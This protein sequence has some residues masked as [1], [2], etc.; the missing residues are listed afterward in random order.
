MGLLSHILPQCYIVKTAEAC[1]CRSRYYLIMMMDHDGHI[2][3]F[4][5]T[6][7]FSKGQKIS[8]TIFDA[9]DSPKNF[10][11]NKKAH[12]R[13]NLFVCLFVLWKNWGNNK[14]IYEIFR[15]LASVA[16]PSLQ[17]S[18]FLTPTYLISKRDEISE[19]SLIRTFSTCSFDRV[20]RCKLR[21]Q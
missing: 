5:T 3:K 6:R 4:H 2:E 12:H 11:K 9:L 18:L 8:R 10:T 1:L 13:S 15:P 17:S 14:L 7:F 16:S 19:A 21:T 20:D